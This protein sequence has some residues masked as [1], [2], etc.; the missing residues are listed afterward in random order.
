MTESFSVN[1]STLLDGLPV[2]GEYTDRVISGLALDSRAIEPGWAFIALAGQTTHG[3]AFAESAVANGAA[4]VLHDGRA[5]P[6]AGLAVPVLAVDGLAGQLPLL[7]QRQWGSINGLDLVA[8]TGTNGKTS[9]AW[10]LAQ[11]ID[12]A[13]IGTL[14]V[15]RPG[16]QMALDHTTPD[17]LS[18]HRLLAR[19]RDAGE[20]RVVMEASSHALDQGRLDGLAWSSTIF[21]ALGHDHLDYHPD[22]AAYGEAKARLFTDFDSRRSLINA[23]DAFGRKLIERLAGLRELLPYAINDPSVACRIHPIGLTATATQA[24]ILLDGDPILLS[25]RLIGRVNLYNLLIVG[26]ELRA[27]GLDSLAIAERLSALQPVPGRMEALGSQ[28][29]VTAVIDYAHTPDALEK[30]LAGLA[31]LHNGELVC[32]FGCGGDRDRAKRPMMGRIAESLADQIILTNDNPRSE[33]PLAIIREIQ[34]GMHRP[35]RARVISDRAA[36]IE[37]AVKDARHGDV[38]LIAGKGHEDYQQI[39]D[40]RLPF[41]DRATALNCLEGNA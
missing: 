27:R 24:E 17:R 11:A 26:I 37:R 35:D 23:D 8:V 36:A 3:L 28:R 14:G 19:L 33:D 20:A 21:T 25:S 31:E 40:Q 30:A 18:I 41:S 9:V 4:A 32:V 10:L 5:T 38:V 15:G 34:S 22:L 2:T 12:G 16:Q 1:L 6:P 39:G 7:A 29:G 13:M